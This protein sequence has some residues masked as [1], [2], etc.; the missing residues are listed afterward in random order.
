MPG[1]EP[2]GDE[3]LGGPTPAMGFPLVW[4]DP[5][6]PCLSPSPPPEARVLSWV[7]GSRDFEVWVERG[8]WRPV[9]EAVGV[10]EWAPFTGREC[11]TPSG[12]EIRRPPKW[13]ERFCAGDED[14]FLGQTVSWV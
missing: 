1:W 4:V 14:A 13:E 8:A 5:S 9:A 2:P 11:R 7:L 6:S 3:A 10:P 12:V